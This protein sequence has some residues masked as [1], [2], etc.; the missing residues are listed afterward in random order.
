MNEFES[1]LSAIDP[2]PADTTIADP[3]A[4]ATSV[5]PSD[6][7]NID[8]E[9]TATLTAPAIIEVLGR[10]GYALECRT[11]FTSLDLDLLRRKARDKK[12]A[13]GIDGVKFSSLFLAVNTTRILRNGAP[14]EL[15]GVAPI[16][17]TSRQLWARY[18][19]GSAVEAVRAF[20]GR[21]AYVEST[22]QRLM[23]EAG[24]GDDVY[25]VDPTA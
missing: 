6:L 21:E 8:A 9:L 20:L 15:D 22:A 18:A 16:T 2:D 19:A 24:W 17:F 12:F 11:D 13:D 3:D 23:R 7:D 5:E 10:P 1:R 4:P 25:A 14:L